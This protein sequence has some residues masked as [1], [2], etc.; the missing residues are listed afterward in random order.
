MKELSVRAN[1]LVSSHK[2][3]ERLEAFLSTLKSDVDFKL[4]TKQPKE[5]F[6][7][8]TR[9]FRIIPSDK[10]IGRPKVE[11]D[12]EE[13]S[14]LR[15]DEELSFQEIAERL[16]VS[17]GNLYRKLPEGVKEATKHLDS[18]KRMKKRE[19]RIERERGIN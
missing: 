18:V 19:K 7:I 1:C 9:L 10:P 16:G 14:R 4:L 11:F 13:A 15:V 3:M 12:V 5:E 6:V 2:D 8:E 17:L